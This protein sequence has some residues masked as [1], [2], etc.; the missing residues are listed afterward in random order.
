M[1]PKFT[2]KP[3]SYLADEYLELK[4]QQAELA[5]R[6]KAIKEALILMNAPEVQGKYGRVKISEVQPGY[7]NDAKLMAQHLSESVLAKCK[8]LR[9][10]SFRFNV[11]ARK[12][13]AKVQEPA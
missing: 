4:A 12:A 8:R 3:G 9:A 2:Y 7:V 13:D 11:T 6:E 5:A 10:G 1:T